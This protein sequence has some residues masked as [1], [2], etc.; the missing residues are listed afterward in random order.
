MLKKWICILLAGALLLP[1]GCEKPGEPGKD[2]TKIAIITAES[3]EAF[4]GARILAEKKENILT[5]T[6]SGSKSE[7]ET[8]SICTELAKDPGVGAIVFVPAIAGIDK[9]AS[10]VREI[11]KD[12]LFL[13]GAE[14]QDA[15]F[16]AQSADVVL[17]QDLAAMGREIVNEAYRMGA[18]RIIHYSFARHLLSEPVLKR[19]E[20]M[21]ARCEELGLSFMDVTTPDPLS[22]EGGKEEAR[23]FVEEDVPQQVGD[24]GANTA[25]FATDP[26]IMAELVKQV[27]ECGAILPQTCCGSP[28]H[29]YT[30]M[31]GIEPTYDDPRG[32]IG[33]IARGIAPYGNTGR[34]ATWT[35][36]A[37]IF[38]VEA[39]VKY[40]E[41]YLAGEI[42]KGADMEKMQSVAD[43]ISGGMVHLSKM[44]HAPNCLMFVCDYYML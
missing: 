17:T 4:E 12:I 24:Y 18:K 27:M 37:D 20:V 6:F 34:M 16:V 23:Q 32:V 2:V 33:Q 42:K 19:R 13:A 14:P 44:A 22:A 5:R 9:A 11:R 26:T 29:G 8:V 3:G 31:M 1:A 30:E 36:S 43:E 21:V 40:A 25:F 10:A 15:G 35:Q 41:G 7:A 28:Y 38:M 39:G